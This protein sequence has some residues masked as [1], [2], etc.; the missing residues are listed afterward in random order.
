MDAKQAKEIS[1]NYSDLLLKRIETEIETKCC[2]G[3][4]GLI[5]SYKPEDRSHIEKV[6]ESLKLNGFN[7]IENKRNCSL[8]ISWSK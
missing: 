8:C 7:V 4:Y 6:V 1:D 2:V 5:F 3:R